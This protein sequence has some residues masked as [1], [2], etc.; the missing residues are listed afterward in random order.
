MNKFRLAFVVLVLT[1]A[2]IGRAPQKPSV[3]DGISNVTLQSAENRS[4]LSWQVVKMSISCL[5][6]GCRFI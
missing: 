1:I 5:T 2:V 4:D 6:A 3:Y